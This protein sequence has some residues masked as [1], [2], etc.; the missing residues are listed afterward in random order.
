[1][2]AAVVERPAAF[3]DDIAVTQRRVIASEWIKLRSLRSTWFSFGAAIVLDIGLGIL[4]SGLR[5]HDAAD[6]HVPARFFDSIEVSLRGMFLAQLA[7]GVLGVL[8]ITGEYATGMIRA[9]LSAAPRRVP[10]FVGKI[11]VFGG[12]TFTLSAIMGLI[13]FLGGQAILHGDGY[14]VSLS[15]PGAA[16]AVVGVGLYLTVVGLLALGC[17]F[18]FRSTG[19]A[20]AAL[21][22]L[23]LVLPILGQ[24]LPSSI[25]DHVNKYLPMLAGWQIINT[26][27]DDPNL[28]GPWTGLGV[29]ALYALV[30]LAIGVVALMRRDA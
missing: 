7:V 6:H 5:G 14:G 17:G 18:T 21:F 10:V 24:A 15:S 19:G 23:L 2:T 1:M 3:D 26:H 20:I 13:A 11:V 4:F 22:G 30:M 8:V 9:S 16:R 27:S 28:L 29:F 25:A 12:V